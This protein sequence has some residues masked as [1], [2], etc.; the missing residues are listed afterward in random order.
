GGEWWSRV[1][2]GTRKKT[3]ARGPRES[4]P[5]RAAGGGRPAPP[6]PDARTSRPP[7]VSRGPGAEEALRPP[8]QQEDRERVDEG[9]A[10]LGHVLLER[11]IE[12]ADQERGVE[13]TGN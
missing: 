10:A 5:T 1:T 13:A 12:H 3:R 9:R 8:E 2:A 7:R 4:S 6:L 11:E